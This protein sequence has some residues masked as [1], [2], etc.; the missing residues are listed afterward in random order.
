MGRP[1]SVFVNRSGQRSF[2]K[3]LK[4]DRVIND[5]K[6]TFQGGVNKARLKMMLGDRL[7]TVAAA[8]KVPASRAYG[9]DGSS[10][11]RFRIGSGR[12]DDTDGSIWNRVVDGTGRKDAFFAVYV[13]EEEMGASN[14]AGNFK[15]TNLLEA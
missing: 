11:E 13:E 8:R 14:P 5:P 15:I 12:W 6:G 7:V 9:I 4:N 10:I 3:N 1:T 2:W